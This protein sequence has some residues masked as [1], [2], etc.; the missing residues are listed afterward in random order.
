MNLL[1]LNKY[2]FL[3]R[4][5]LVSLAM[6]VLLGTAILHLIPQVNLAFKNFLEIQSVN[7]LL[8]GVWHK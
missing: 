3:F 5:F 4:M 2:N 7:F 6:G 1:R 8:K